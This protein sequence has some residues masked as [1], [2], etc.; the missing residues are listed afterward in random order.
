MK[1]KPSEITPA[2]LFSNRRRL[3]NSA[4]AL[5]LV[6]AANRVDAYTFTA[7]DIS[8]R[9]LDKTLE[10][11]TYKEIT[12]YNNFYEFGVDKSDPA[13]L[14]RHFKTAPWSIKVSGE[15]DQLGT[16]DIDRLLPKSKLEER[17]YRFRCVEAWSMVVPWIGIPLS[18]ILKRVAPTS[19]AKFVEFRTL[20]D[21]T[22][23]PGQKRQILQWP[24][25]EG[26]RMDEAMHPLTLLAT[27]LY[28]KPLPN[29]NGAPVRL[30]VPWKYGFKS[31]KSIVSINLTASQPQ[32]TWNHRAPNE[33]GFYAN[34]NPAVDHPRWSQKTERRLGDFFRHPTLPFNGYQA[35]VA[36]LYRGMDL[37]RLF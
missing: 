22:Q 37:T 27:G 32:T 16:Y 36:D 25:T 34:V 33:Y 31:I 6:T 1:I 23:M 35:D 14:A 19:K 2:S 17:L 13:K 26:L 9:S 3:L 4:I 21:P 15:C 29:Q 24:Y 5:G 8:K 11:N 28:G 20:F 18:T 30:V 7:A 10:A 12:T